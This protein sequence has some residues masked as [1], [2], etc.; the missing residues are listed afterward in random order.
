L[1]F[2]SS[3]GGALP[4][5]EHTNIALD[6]GPLDFV[7]TTIASLTSGSM[8]YSNG[9][10]LQELNIGGAG[11]VLG[12]AAGVPVWQTSGAAAVMTVN[13]QMVYFDGSRTALN[14]GN[15]G[16]TLTVSAGGLPVWTAPAGSTWTNEG[17]D[18]DDNVTNLSVSVSDQDIYQVIYSTAD[19]DAASTSITMRLNG[20]TT[21]TYDTL[22]SA[23]AAGGTMAAS[24]STAI[25][26]WLLGSGGGGG[27]M[28]SG[29]CYVYKANSDFQ[30]R[31]AVG[32]NFSGQNFQNTTEPATPVNNVTSGINE[33]I[34]GAI[35]DF[36]L[37]Y[38]NES[39]ATRQNITGSMQVNSMSY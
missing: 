27:K 21:S 4:N 9:S 20:V 36:T 14:I 25:P 35:T 34:T 10:A 7:N 26:K 39:S 19:Q 2:G 32:A 16:D 8:T 22:L 29:V 15:L 1:G 17:S 13:G 6:G 31:M 38:I 5:H 37:E 23:N 28:N 3:G 30:A 12:V 11:T 24:E 18:T 33:T